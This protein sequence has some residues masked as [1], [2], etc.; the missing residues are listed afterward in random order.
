MGPKQALAFV[1]Q[2]GIV[3]MS[4]KGPVPSLAEAI[5]GQLFRGS[6]WSHPKAHAMFTVFEFLRDDSDV[7]TCRLVGGKVTFVHR[8]LWPALIGLADRWGSQALAAVREE[9]TTAGRHRVVETPFPN[10]VPKTALAEAAWLTATEAEALLGPLLQALPITTPGAT[11]RNP[12]R[13]RRPA[14]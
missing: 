13:A 5:A 9:H 12:G 8:R 11:R 7:L 2:H 14:R 4:A 6:W 3:L 10:W 1:E